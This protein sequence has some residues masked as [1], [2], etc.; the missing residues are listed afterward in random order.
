MKASRSYREFLLK[1]LQDPKE[2][3]LYLDA[4][5]EDEDPRVFLI[6]LK[7]VADAYGGMTKMARHTK[8]S[9]EHLYRMLS[10]RG[11][12]A[13]L[14]IGAL[15]ASLGFRLSIKAAGA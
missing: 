12:P 7:D 5:L 11:N 8:M 15:L 4:C 6:A 9:R 3:A 10:K 2:A 14:G 13:F 1:N